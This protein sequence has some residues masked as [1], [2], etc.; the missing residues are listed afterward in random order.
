MANEMTVVRKLNALI[1][2]CR[3]NQNSGHL[4]GIVFTHSSQTQV[5]I[6]VHWKGAWKRQPD[7]HQILRLGC[8]TGCKHSCNPSTPKSTPPII[9]ALRSEGT[10]I[11]F[12]LLPR[13]PQTLPTLTLPI[14]SLAQGPPHTF[15]TTHLPHCMYCRP[16]PHM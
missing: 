4:T 8:C 14:L 11:P 7:R 2:H 1:C 16:Q 6:L 15:R 12:W 10:S 5:N 13:A 9:L 3:H